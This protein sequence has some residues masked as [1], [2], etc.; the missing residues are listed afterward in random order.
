MNMFSSIS[1]TW[2]PYSAS[3]QPTLCRPR[4]P[5]RIILV[6]D[7]QTDIPNSPLFPILV[8]TQLLRTVFPMRDHQLGFRINFVR[9]VPQDLQCLTMISATCVVEDVSLRLDFLT[10]KV[11][12][13][14]GAS[15][16]VTWVQADT[17]SAACPSQPRNLARASITVSAVIWDADEP[18]A[19]ESSLTMSPRS[20][21]L[22]LYFCIFGFQLRV[23]EVTYVASIM[24]SGLPVCLFVLR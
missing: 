9:E 1:S 18:E 3:F 8:P 19:P 21:T 17:A 13:N 23:L 2:E 22:P 16:N 12:S 5:I 15:S 20:T 14:L 10:Q 7:E 6:F 24:Q 11:L 4:I